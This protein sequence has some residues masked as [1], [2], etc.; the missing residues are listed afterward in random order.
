MKVHVFTAGFCADNEVLVSFLYFIICVDCFVLISWP[1]E[2][3]NL[4]ILQIGAYI[5]YNSE[6]SSRT[7]VD[8]FFLVVSNLLESHTLLFHLVKCISSLFS[9]QLCLICL[10]KFCLSLLIY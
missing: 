8:F 9:P 10:F 2:M 6:G 3:T 7:I 5:L 1:L 4:I